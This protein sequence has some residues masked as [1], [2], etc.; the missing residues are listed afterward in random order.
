MI[1]A[2]L[3]VLVLLAGSSAFAWQVNQHYTNNTGQTAYD[4]TKILLGNITCTDTMLNQPFA[5]FTRT[6][7]RV[8]SVFHWYNGTVA[9]GEKAHCCFST[10]AP[11]APPYVALWTDASGS[12]IGLAGPVA[13]PYI[14][15]NQVT[16]EIQFQLENQWHQ[17]TGSGY[18]PETGNG[19]GDYVG[20][21][22]MIDVQY[23]IDVTDRELE[24]LD[25]TMLEAGELT[26]LPIPD[27]TGPLN[28]GEII[29][30][31]VGSEPIELGTNIVLYYQMEG[32]GG[33]QAYDVVSYKYGTKVPSLTGWGIIILVSL[34]I[35]S[36]LIIVMRRRRRLA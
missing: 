9:P 1:L 20:P 23:A 10:N 24:E 29:S 5:D 4:L 11:V 35:L 18:P 12:F 15:Y 30:A 28:G 22:T 16:N 26:W 7:F 21:I 8:Y 25:S 19:L 6:G 3:T 34:L 32:P 17:W 27:L 14:S 2:L 13:I 31:L 36:T 33:E